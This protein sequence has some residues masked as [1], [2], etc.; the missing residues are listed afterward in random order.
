MFFFNIFH[1]QL[2]NKHEKESTPSFNS[3]NSTDLCERN[4]SNFPDP[5]AASAAV[6]EKLSEPLIQQ[7]AAVSE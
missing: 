2:L 7:L 5:A 1:F 3:I 4:N 6:C